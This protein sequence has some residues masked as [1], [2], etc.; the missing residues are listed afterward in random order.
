MHKQQRCWLLAASGLIL[1]LAVLLFVIDSPLPVRADAPVVTHFIAPGGYCEYAVPC[2]ASLQA[3]V[4]AAT[5]GDVIKLASGTYTGVISRA[6]SSQ[7]VYISKTLTIRGGFKITDWESLPAP[8]TAPTVLD[9]QGLG[10]VLKVVGVANLTIDG[11]QMVHGSADQGAGLALLNSQAVI[12][13]CMIYANQAISVGGGLLI[14]GT[15]Q[16]TATDTSVYSN[17]A[18]S[19]GGGIAIISGTVAFTNTYLYAN[20]AGAQGGGLTLAGGTLRMVNAMIYSNT[21]TGGT[22]AGLFI[23]NGT[24]IIIHPTLARN[25]GGDGTA[26]AV[27]NG[28]AIVSY[29]ILVSHTVG[30]SASAGTTSTFSYT[31]WGSGTWANGVNKA[32]AGIVI[33]ATNYTGDPKF[34]APEIGNYHIMT[35]SAAVDMAVGTIVLFDIDNMSREGVYIG[36]PDLGADEVKKGGTGTAIIHVDVEPGG[37]IDSGNKAAWDG[38]PENRRGTYFWNGE[39]WVTNDTA[40]HMLFTSVANGER[41]KEYALLATLTGT[42]PVGT[43]FSNGEITV[44]RSVYNCFYVSPNTLDTLVYTAIEYRLTTPNGKRVV[45]RSRGSGHGLDLPYFDVYIESPDPVTTHTL[46]IRWDSVVIDNAV[47]FE[48]ALAIWGSNAGITATLV[49]GSPPERARYWFDLN[50]GSDMGGVTYFIRTAAFSSEVQQSSGVYPVE[51]RFKYMGAG[52]QL[53][54]VRLRPALLSET[55]HAPLCVPFV[56]K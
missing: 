28:A 54:E 33:S 3:A 11:L 52:N 48:Q 2:Y 56:K 30:I 25:T 10:G 31:L 46:A 50:G 12:S 26:I 1:V 16:L 37:D 47:P 9:A 23:G 15:S 18:G 7:V 41:L 4:D 55:R 8:Y 6:G 45:L 34:V 49:T 13:R 38:T 21:L 32:G 51:F 24:A 22:G 39:K 19:R 35:T 36:P 53:R 43:V 20:Q 14:S 42:T 27:T 17:T 29:A 40:A 5:S 44:T